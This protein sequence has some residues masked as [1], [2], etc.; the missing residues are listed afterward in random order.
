MPRNRLW[1]VSGVIERIKAIIAQDQ[2]L[3][4]RVEE[5]KEEINMR[6]RTSPF[7]DSKFDDLETLIFCCFNLLG[8]RG[9]EKR[10]GDAHKII[11]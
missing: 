10:S 5:L 9:N 11:N 4:K 7:R 6:S 2:K 3:R 1:S 8:V